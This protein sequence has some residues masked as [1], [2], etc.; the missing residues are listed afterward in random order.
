MLET[1]KLNE[2][3]KINRCPSTYAE[4]TWYPVHHWSP[5]LRPPEKVERRL[6]SYPILGSTTTTELKLYPDYS[7]IEFFFVSNTLRI[8]RLDRTQNELDPRQKAAQGFISAD[9]IGWTMWPYGLLRRGILSSWVSRRHFGKPAQKPLCHQQI[10]SQ[11]GV[12][13]QG[14]DIQELG[15]ANQNGKLQSRSMRCP[16]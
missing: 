1:K 6:L 8:I 9:E 15:L 13:T 12:K 2:D 11:E 3:V 14:L 7:R 5:L 10:N 16:L 4:W